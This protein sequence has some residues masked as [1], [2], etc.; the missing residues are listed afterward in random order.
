[1]FIP[2]HRKANYSEA[3][4]YHCIS[5]LFF[6]QKMTQKLVTRS[7][8]DETLGHYTY[9]SNNLPTNQVGTQKLQCTML[10]HLHRKQWK[11]GSYT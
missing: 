5:L 10:L 2:V 9:T 7:I 1:M 3:K 4:V 6:M 11:T 8:R